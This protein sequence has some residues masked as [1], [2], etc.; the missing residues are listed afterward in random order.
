MLPHREAPLANAV[1]A[2]LVYVALKGT[3]DTT[4]VTPSAISRSVVQ[5]A[6]QG[7]ITSLLKKH[8]IFIDSLIEFDESRK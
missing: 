2:T 6:G 7:S 1:T 4:R 5:R 8:L 3:V